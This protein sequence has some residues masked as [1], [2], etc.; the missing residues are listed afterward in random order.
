LT[1]QRRR[2]NHTWRSALMRR[3][4]HKH[5]RRAVAFYKVHYG[6]KEPFKVGYLCHADLKGGGAGG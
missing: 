5:T 4:K 1:A 3:K 6:F 2:R